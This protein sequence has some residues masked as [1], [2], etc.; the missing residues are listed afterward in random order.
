MRLETRAR[1]RFQKQSADVPSRPHRSVPVPSTSLASESTLYAQFRSEVPPTRLERTRADHRYAP[2]AERKN[3][4]K[5]ETAHADF[6]D[7]L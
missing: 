7:N 5:G 6:G 2:E 3:A 4:R 1:L